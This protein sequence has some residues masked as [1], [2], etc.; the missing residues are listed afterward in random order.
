MSIQDAIDLIERQQNIL[1]EV[2]TG[3]TIQTLDDEYKANRRNL[4]RLLARLRMNDPF[5]WRDLWAWYGF[6]KDDYPTYQSRRHVVHERADSILSTLERRLQEGVTDWGPKPGVEGWSDLEVRVEGLKQELDAATT[7]DD[8]QDVGRRSRE[9]VI[10]LANLLFSD[11]MVP[12]GEDMPGRSD[13]KRRIDLALDE[14]LPGPSRADLRGLVRAAFKLNQ[15]VTHGN[16][17]AAVDA[18]A[19]AQATVLLVRVLHR[20]WS[21]WEPF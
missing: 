18:F 21:D 6:Y 2:A 7:Q 4:A 9:I 16:S 15:T 11:W 20:A 13:A 8:L 17:V 5:P 12:K 1:I 19:A 3:T 14:M 10:D